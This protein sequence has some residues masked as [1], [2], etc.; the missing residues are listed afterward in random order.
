M[1]ATALRADAPEFHLLHCQRAWLLKALAWEKRG[2][3]KLA[4]V[5]RLT[6]YRLL[7]APLSAFGPEFAQL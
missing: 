5:M 6:V 1:I 7:C 4:A 2:G 3:S